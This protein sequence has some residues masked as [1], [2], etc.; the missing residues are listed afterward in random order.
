MLRTFERHERIRRFLTAHQSVT[1]EALSEM[2]KVSPSTIRR[3]LQRMEQ[4][5]L[6]QRHYGGAVAKTEIVAMPEPPFAQRQSQQVLEKSRIGQIAAA[7]VQDCE[8][9]LMS[10]GTTTQEVARHLRSR[11][12]LTVITNA[13]NVANLLVDSSTQTLV[14]TGGEIRE[15]EMDLV[16]PLSTSALR[17]LRADKVILGM[18]GLHPKFG[19]TL[20]DLREAE[21]AQSMIKCAP[22][23]IVVADHTKLGRLA[24]SLVAPISAM[25]ILVTDQGAPEDI[26]D[27]L[28]VLGVRVELA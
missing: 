18:T 23:L 8:T 17:S 1:V 9:V 12:G 3:D 13:L 25:S 26:L 4:Q 7:L 11:R 27:D 15:G 2:L 10:G 20:D 21:I 28:R 24:P 14:V 16:G 6:I 19:L 22:E 5:G